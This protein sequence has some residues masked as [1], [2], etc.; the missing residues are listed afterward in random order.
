MRIHDEITMEAAL[1]AY[2]D[3]GWIEIKRLFQFRQDR[4]KPYVTLHVRCHDKLSNPLMDYITDCGFHVHIEH[5]YEHG[6]I[7]HINLRCEICGEP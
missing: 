4:E 2:R 1:A 7:G 6:I 5:G 3:D